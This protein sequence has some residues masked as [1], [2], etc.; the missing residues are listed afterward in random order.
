MSESSEKPRGPVAKSVVP[1]ERFIDDPGAA[2]G[3]GSAAA[4]TLELLEETA[5]RV[6]QLEG[7]L[8]TLHRE[9]RFVSD[10]DL[11]QLGIKPE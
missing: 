1:T 10:H 4:D 2:F 9:K 3:E 5:N 7:A 11:L 6:D 8:R